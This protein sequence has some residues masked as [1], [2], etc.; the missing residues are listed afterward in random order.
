MRDIC[1]P[2]VSIIVPAFNAGR[3]IG[4]AINSLLSQ[5][6]KDFELIICDDASIDDTRKIIDSFSDARIVCITNS[7]NMGPGLSRDRAIGLAKGKWIAFTDADD[8]WLS[9]RLETLLAAVE[10]TENVMVFDDIM[11]CHDT[12]GGMIPWRVLRGNNSFGCNSDH[13]QHIPIEK[14]VCLKR[15]LIKPLIPLFFIKKHCI[16]HSNLSVHEDNEFFLN[17]LSCGLNLRFVSK[18]MYYYRITPGSATSNVNRNNLL[19]DVLEDAVAKFSYSPIIQSALRQKINMVTRD[20]CYMPF[21]VS[22]KKGQ[23]ITSLKMLFQSPWLAIEFLSRLSECIVYHIH[24]LR[25]GGRV[26]G[27][28]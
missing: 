24:R 9:D 26:R 15:L 19:I 23:L 3:T 8:I 12:P 18:P 17:I 13:I 22:L 7:D 1:T 2:I 11:E 14:Y 16:K 5:T 21:L 6:F 20:E 10:E 27:M 4:A 25:H 28:R